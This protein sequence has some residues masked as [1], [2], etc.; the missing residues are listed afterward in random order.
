[1]RTE[2]EL[3]SMIDCI[4][5]TYPNI[6]NKAIGSN[7]IRA[8]HDGFYAALKVALGEFESFAELNLEDFMESTF[9]KEVR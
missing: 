5:E 2:K 3:Q 4:K 8:Y 1:M 7:P 9:N 6:D